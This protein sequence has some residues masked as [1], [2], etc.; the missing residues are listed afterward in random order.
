MCIKCAKTHL[1]AS[2]ISKKFSGVIQRTPTR[3]EET[4]GV[5]REERGGKRR[6][7]GKR[8]G[9]GKGGEGS[10]TLRC[11]ISHPDRKS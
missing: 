10:P 7:Q 11:L 5:E 4:L 2:V 1:R 6:G 3:W 8:G 9:E